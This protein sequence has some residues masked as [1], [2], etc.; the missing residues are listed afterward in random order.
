MRIAVRAWGLLLSVAAWSAMA[1][2]QRAPEERPFR[3]QHAMVVSIHHAA[4]DAGVAVL[5]QGG[6]AVDAAVA[7][8]FALAVVYPQAGNIGGGGFMLVRMHSG[9]AHFLDYRERAPGAAAAGMYLDAGGKVVPGLSTVGYK[10]IGVPGTVAGLTYAE[11][12]YGRLGLAKVMA[13]AI[14]L[15]RDGF[16][17]SEEEARNLEH[18]RNVA[19]F[20]LSRRIFQRDG[21]FYKPGETFQQPE[22]AKTLQRIA[23]DPQDFYKGSMAKELAQSVQKG[24]GLITAADLA[25]YEVKE[26]TPLEGDYRGFTW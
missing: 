5:R 13:P 4:T 16:V 1:A 14:A 24:G 8:G 22:L 10:A 12:R 19:R 17:L 23:A 15:A 11:K 26:R 21:N 7:V 18:A 6:N 9:A 2:A 20:P 25:A 3:A